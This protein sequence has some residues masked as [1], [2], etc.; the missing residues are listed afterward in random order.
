VN[1]LQI[2]ISYKVA[3]LPSRLIQ[4]PVLICCVSLVKSEWLAAQTNADFHRLNFSPSSNFL[5]RFINTFFPLSYI[6]SYFPS[7]FLSSFLSCFLLPVLF[8]FIYLLIR[9]RFYITLPIYLSF[10][11]LSPTFYHLLCS[12]TVFL[13]PYYPNHCLHYF[14]TPLGL[15]LFLLSLPLSYFAF[16]LFISKRNPFCS[17]FQSLTLSLTPSIVHSI[18]FIFSSVQC[19]VQCS[20]SFFHP[21][22]TPICQTH[23]MA[24]HKI[25]PHD[26]GMRNSTCP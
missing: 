13:L 1:C 10:L 6:P 3:L 26:E 23:M 22:L 16:F 19:Q 25:S 17:V 15:L 18:I 2:V 21:L 8:H 14:P 24:H 4:T 7:S 12:F 5:S 11:I 20:A 9:L